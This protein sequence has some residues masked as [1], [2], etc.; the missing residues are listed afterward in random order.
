MVD[1]NKGDALTPDIRARLVAMEVATYKDDHFF[2]AAPALEALRLLL[3]RTASRRSHGRGGRKLLVIKSR[4]AHLHAEA[5]REIY[6]TLP[7]EERRDGYCPRL[8]RCL[9][10]TLE[11]PQL[12]GRPTTLRYSP[13][14]ASA[15]GGLH[16]AA[17]SL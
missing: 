1:V 12:S 11:T 16:F 5:D 4:K 14:W 6:I 15:V 2:A 17:L 13:S 7:P 8:L 3:S 10:G 9:Y